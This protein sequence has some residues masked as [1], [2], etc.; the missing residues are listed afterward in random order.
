MSTTLTVYGEIIMPKTETNNSI[1]LLKAFK[2]P[3]ISGR[4]TLTYHL[5]YDDKKKIYFRIFNNTGNGFHSKEWVALDDITEALENAEEPFNSIVLFTLFKHQSL[6]SP[7]FLFAALKSERLVQAIKG[8]QRCH[9]LADPKP[10][11]E[12]VQKLLSSKTKPKLAWKKA[13][14]RKKAAVPRKRTV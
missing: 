6:N 7:A 4:S 10:F 5:G 3:S 14:A 8:K 2:C 9:E 11:L 1:H 12:K 13:P